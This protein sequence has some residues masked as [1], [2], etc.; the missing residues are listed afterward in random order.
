M[1]S[2]NIGKIQSVILKNATILEAIKRK[3]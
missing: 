2:L 3:K 1:E